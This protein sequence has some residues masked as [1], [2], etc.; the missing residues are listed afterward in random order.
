VHR[1]KGHGHAHHHHDHERSDS[2]GWT[3]PP[4]QPIDG[5]H[6]DDCVYLPD[7]VRP[8]VQTQ[9]PL[10]H[11]DLASLFTHYDPTAVDLAPTTQRLRSFAPPDVLRSGC[12][13]C[14]AL[15]TLRI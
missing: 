2:S 9:V 12:D 3:E 5:E 8:V 14:V 11:L 15:R 4:V 6:D 13:L 10:E 1:T 7:A